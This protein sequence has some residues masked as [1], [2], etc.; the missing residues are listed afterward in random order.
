[1]IVKGDHAMGNESKLLER[2]GSYQFSRIVIGKLK[3]GAD[4]LE[5]IKEIARQEKIRTGVILAGLG[6]LSKGVFRNA[7]IMPPDYKMKDE[8][9]VY[10][11][12]EKT[13]ELV[14]LPGWIAT[15]ENGE[16]DVHAHFT[17]SLVMDDKIVSMG[18]HLTTGTIASIK[19]IIV[20]GVID[21][22]K[23]KAAID[24]NINQSEIYF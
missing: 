18:G 9:R 12:L 24:P 14:S 7:K 3:I 22:A 5:G 21:D 8:Y 20:I 4:L 1:M 2:T 15:K 19:V 6:A 23:I 13:M 16:I 10:L 17:T 11:E